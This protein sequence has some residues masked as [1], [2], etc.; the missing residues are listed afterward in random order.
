MLGF[1][2]H[3]GGSH[4]IERILDTIGHFPVFRG[5]FVIGEAERPGMDAVNI[6]ETACREGAQQVQRGRGLGIG[7]Q[8]PAGIGNPG[9]GSEGQFV[10]DVATIAGQFH[11]V[12]HLGRGAAGLGELTGDLGPP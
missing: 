12:D 3:P 9:L 7:L 10:D 2:R 11:A 6:R 5:L 4:E 8:H 1:G